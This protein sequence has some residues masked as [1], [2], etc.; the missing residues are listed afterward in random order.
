M[1]PL[2]R[3]VHHV[4]LICSDYARSKAFYSEVLGFPIIREVN[5]VERGSFKLDLQVA[6]GLQLELF[7]FPNP[8]PR[9]TRPE[10]CGLRHLAFVVDDI[11][12]AVAELRA[13][14]VETEEVRVD[15]HTGRR[16]TFF[17]DPD[18]LP[19]EMYEGG[20]QSAS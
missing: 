14:G 12:R 9:P 16:F 20:G 1:P 6:P 17:M 19:L 3:S 11:E 15:A 7:S 13:K 8:P 5:R 10:A 2:F 18:G 4:A